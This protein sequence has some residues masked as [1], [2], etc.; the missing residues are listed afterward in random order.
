MTD[1]QKLIEIISNG[2][3]SEVQ[4][5]EAFSN[6]DAIAAELAAMAN[7]G[8][9]MIVFGVKDKTG[10]IVGLDFPALRELGSRVSQIA[11]DAVKPF[12]PV[13]TEVVALPVGGGVSSSKTI[14]RASS[15]GW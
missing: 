12:V 4:F 1:P 13:T 6:S 3:T 5:E 14:R 7:A 8:G 9:G 15:S 2:E 10:E 11:T